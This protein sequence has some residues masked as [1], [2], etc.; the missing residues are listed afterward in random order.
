[1]R[2]PEEFGFLFEP[3][4]KYAHRY[5]YGGRGSAKSHSFA[6][7][8]VLLGRGRRL[9]IL[10][11]REIQDSI[12]D[13]VKTLL[14]DKIKELGLS[15][16]YKSTKTSI[17][18]LN[19]T[20]FSFKGM[21]SRPD[22]L[23]GAEGVD[24][25][26][27]EE[28]SSVS[29]VSIQKLVPTIRKPGSEIWWTWNPENED[30]PVDVMFRSPAGPPPRSIGKNINWDANPFFPDKLREEMEDARR[31]DPDLYAHVWLGE[32]KRNSE[33]RV[34]RNWRE[35]EFET[36]DN[37]ERFYFGGDFGFAIDPAV[38]IRCWIDW[39]KRTLYIDREA[40]K[41]GVEIDYLPA[42]FAGDDTHVP[43][44]W[45]NGK[46]GDESR[47]RFPGIPGALQWPITADSSRPDTIAYLVRRG[48]RVVP[49]K[50]G[51]DSVAEGIEFLKNFDI[52]VHSKHCPATINE[53]IRYSWK[54]DKKTGEVLPVLLDKDNHVID[55]LRYAIEA[56]RHAMKGQ[57]LFDLMREQADAK[58]KAEAEAAGK[59]T[60]PAVAVGS[61]EWFEAL[62]AANAA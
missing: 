22:S 32:Y 27:V 61:A 59:P 11:L 25:V 33:A 54:T 34:F 3:L 4:G 42:F 39:K 19:G 2:I 36:P 7:A 38:L 28:A 37:V 48:F 12:E 13:S 40:H 57:G 15:W 35:E 50:K 55:A 8:L 60:D 58:A 45:E 6:M 52:V 53:L 10:C 1:M 17:I 30:D 20:R 9:R 56:L 16:F 46:F 49:S 21:W 18:G 31:R 5:A 26:W 14:E 29:K 43:P 24:I 51:P 41:V 47:P 23:K 44:R 62:R